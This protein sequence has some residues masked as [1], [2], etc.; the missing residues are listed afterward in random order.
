AVNSAELL[1]RQE[2]IELFEHLEPPAGEEDVAGGGVRTTIGLVGYPNVGKSSTI[3]AL[4]GNKKVSVSATPGKTKHFQTLFLTDRVVLCDCPGLVMP[5]LV[6]SKADMVVGG[7]LPIDQMRDYIGPSALIA[8]LIGRRDLESH[9]GIMINPPREGEDPDRPPTAQE[10][11]DPY[12]YSRG[13]M[14]QNGQP[15]MARAARWIL[16]DVVEGRLLYCWAP[17][18]VDQSEYHILPTRGRKHAP[19]PTPQTIRALQSERVSTNDLDKAFFKKASLGAHSK[20]VSKIL[21][22][23]GWVRYS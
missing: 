6:A 11:L 18:G 23:K 21:P 10:F 7:I 19:A 4:I 14:T 9:Y 8:A 13:F 3:N 22:G 5:T 12:A 16:K 15:D 1:N 17:P 20:G 2:L